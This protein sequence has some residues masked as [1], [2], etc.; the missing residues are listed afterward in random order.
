MWLW[1]KHA[2]QKMSEVAILKMIF[3]VELF[4]NDFADV[5]LLGKFSVEAICR[6]ELDLPDGFVQDV[7]E[8][9]EGFYSEKEEAD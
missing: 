9:F 1:V 3:V 7:L 5:L 6:R 8:E 4:L 2:V